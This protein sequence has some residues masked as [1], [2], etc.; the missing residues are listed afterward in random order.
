VLLQVIKT[1]ELE[2]RAKQVA[3]AVDVVNQATKQL[4]SVQRQVSNTLGAV[5]QAAQRIQQHEQWTPKEVGK[6]A[7][8]RADVAC[9]ACAQGTALQVLCLTDLAVC[10]HQ[11]G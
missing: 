9:S 8:A 10:N 6:G 11:P 5:R 2:Q 7:V 4:D 1:K 3:A